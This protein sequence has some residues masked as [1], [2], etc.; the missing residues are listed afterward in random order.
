MLYIAANSWAGAS[1]WRGARPIRPS[2]RRAGFSDRRHPSCDG[3]GGLVGAGLC[4]DVSSALQ[5]RQEFLV[6]HRSGEHGIVLLDRQTLLVLAERR[7]AILQGDDVI[8]LLI[9]AA[10]G[11]LDAAIGQ[12]SAERD[13]RDSPAPQDEIEVGGRES[14]QTALALD[15]D[16]AGLRLQDVDDLRAPA[17]LTKRPAVDHALE[18]SVG[19]RAQ[20][21]I[22]VRERD[23]CVHDRRARFTVSTVLASMLV[24]SIT[25]F[26]APCNV[27]PSEVKSF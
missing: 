27:P 7:R 15:D 25:G 2:V 17:P 4:L 3:S 21:M 1:R 9:A 26:T 16:V 18:D 23:G 6:S 20:F 13:R 19:R 8:A 14:A 24:A 12:E 11:R 5:P 10:H 22:I